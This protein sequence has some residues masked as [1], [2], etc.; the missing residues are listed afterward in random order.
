MKKTLLIMLFASMFL[1]W[2]STV[3]Q[4][5]D[6]GNLPPQEL[7]EEQEVINEPTTLVIRAKFTDEFIETRQYEDSCNYYFA[8]WVDL[9]GNWDLKFYNV[10]RNEAGWVQND[11]SHWLTGAVPSC[12]LVDWITWRIPLTWDVK[13]ARNSDEYWYTIA[14]LWDITAKASFWLSWLKQPKYDFYEIDWSIE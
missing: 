9:K 8:V 6:Y 13:R 7:Q 12:E 5:V 14:P 11:I 1:A 2:C 10:F 4:P 3:K